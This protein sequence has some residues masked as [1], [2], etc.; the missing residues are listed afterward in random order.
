MPES[1]R[2]GRRGFITGSGL[3]LNV[4]ARPL[5]DKEK[6]SRIASNTWMKYEDGPWDGVE[7]AKYLYKEAHAAL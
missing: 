2:S 5:T 7:G 1:Q 3:L 6:L 4:N